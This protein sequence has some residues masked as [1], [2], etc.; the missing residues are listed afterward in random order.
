MLLIHKP[1]IESVTP[2]YAR[3]VSHI[4]EDG[5]IHTVWAEVDEKYR[6]YLCDERCDAFVIGLLHYA[7]LHNHNIVCE[8]KMGEELYYQITTSLID[9]LS[10][11]SP[12]MNKITIESEIDS[13]QLYCEG[14][15]GTGISCGIDSFEAVASH[16]NNKY[17]NHSITHLCFNNVGSHGDGEC[18]KTLFDERKK[19]AEDFCK[20]Y[21][22]ELVEVNSNIMDEF[23]QM[24]NLTHTYSSVFAVYVLQKLFSYYYYASGHTIFDFQLTDNDKN[25]TSK[26]DLLSLY[27][28]STETLKIYSQGMTLSRLEKTRIVSN[29]KPSYKYLNVCKVQSDNCSRCEKCVRTIMALDALGVLDNYSEVFDIDYYH[30]HKYEYLKTLLCEMARN[31]Q[32]YIDLYPY[33]KNQISIGTRFRALP[34]VVFC[35]LSSRIKAPKLRKFIKR[36]ING[37]K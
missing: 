4:D 14:K 18:A 27:C 36:I 7:M 34:S 16:S 19:R 6:N 17:P 10:K 9:A 32:T 5:V 35:F 22:Y 25:D 11:S 12:R 30:N 29:Y 20:E 37:K 26:Y 2:G 31:N 3:L 1:F 24:H 28:F 15:V 33:F 13:T 8:G 21:G 23:R